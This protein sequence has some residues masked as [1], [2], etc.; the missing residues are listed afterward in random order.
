MPHHDEYP[1]TGELVRAVEHEAVMNAPDWIINTTDATHSPESSHH[2]VARCAVFVEGH[3]V[4]GP[5]TIASALD[6]V[7]QENVQDSSDPH[8]SQSEDDSTPRAFVWVSLV[9]PTMEHMEPIARLFHLHS[10]TV[11]D[12]V[13]ARQRP[14]LEILG[15]YVFI[16]ART[17]HYDPSPVDSTN[18]FIETNELH[19]I[20]GKDFVL[21]IRHGDVPIPDNVRQRLERSPQLT[22]VGPASVAYAHLD[23]L[24]DDY[25]HIAEELEEKVDTMEDQVFIPE[26]PVHIEPIYMLKRENLEMRHAL[27][28]MTAVL[29]TLSVTKG[30]TGKSVR[31]LY[32]DILDHHTIAADRIISYDERLSTLLDSAV[33]K[34]SLQQNTDMRK[35]SA[36]A[37]MAAVPTLIAGIYGMNFD[38]MPETHWADGYFIVL[39]V[40][41]STCVGLWLIFRRNN[42]L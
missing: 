36:W 21:T 14:K 33:A 2:P 34:V 10:L 42:W 24:V 12:I 13:Q 32:G 9:S 15:D 23:W 31:S 38:N 35:I 40:M 26:S 18:E 3:K 16:V 20:R 37:A 29:K 6:R 1:D 11:E 28:P 8:P 41:L 7:H 30:T 27:D 19:I 5:F 22:S 4:D 25:L 17:V 39:I